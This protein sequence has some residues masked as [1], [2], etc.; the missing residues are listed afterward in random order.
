[1]TNALPYM[2]VTA[3]VFQI[4]STAAEF[5]PVDAITSIGARDKK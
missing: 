4:S 1:M 2:S 3:S 5:T